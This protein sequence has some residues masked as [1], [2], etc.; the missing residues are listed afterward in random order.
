MQLEEVAIRINYFHGASDD[1]LRML[2]VDRAL[3]PTPEEWYAWYAEDYLRPI[4]E[5]V[6]YQLIWELDGSTVG[7]S[8]TDRIL[9]GDQAFMHLHILK[10]GD[11]K[12]GLGVEFVR[13]SARIYFHVLKLQRLFCE[14]NAFNVAPNRTLQRAGF[15]YLFTHDAQ[16]SSIN[17][18]QTTTRWVLGRSDAI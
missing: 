11:R 6:N 7:F 16:P 18:P 8:S 9:Y 3:L 5:R 2:G 10:S 13:E 14:P 4:D 12:R 1:Y 15:R 17:S